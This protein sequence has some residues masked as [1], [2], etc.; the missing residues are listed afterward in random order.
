MKNTKKN[1]GVFVRYLIVRASYMAF[2]QQPLSPLRTLLFLSVLRTGDGLKAALLY[3]GQRLL[4]V[5]R[6]AALLS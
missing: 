1:Q 4:L 6:Y 2:G 3:Y 5:L